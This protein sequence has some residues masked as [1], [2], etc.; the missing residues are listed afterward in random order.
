M[1]PVST[2][3]VR[4]SCL[5]S[6]DDSHMTATVPQQITL[7]LIAHTH[8]NLLVQQWRALFMVL[9]PSGESKQPP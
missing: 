5:R 7:G 2:S 8:R 9:P 4:E 1:S 3:M 6:D